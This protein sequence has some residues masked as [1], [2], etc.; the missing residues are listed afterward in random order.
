MRAHLL[1]YGGAPLTLLY[2]L[3]LLGFGISVGLAYVALGGG[4]PSSANVVGPLVL[5]AVAGV[6]IYAIVRHRHVVAAPGWSSELV[7]LP[8]LRGDGKSDQTL[9]KAA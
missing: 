1:K 2:V 5:A 6:A 8:G 3:A 4:V 7:Q 9:R